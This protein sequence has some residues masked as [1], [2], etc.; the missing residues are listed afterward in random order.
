MNMSMCRLGCIGLLAVAFAATPML[1]SCDS[2]TK[3][4]DMAKSVGLDPAQLA[5]K[6]GS[7]SGDVGGL[8][9]SMNEL[10][11]KAGTDPKGAIDK[12]SA[13]AKSF[14]A[15]NSAVSGALNKLGANPDVLKSWLGGAGSKASPEQLKALT[16]SMSKFGADSSKFQGVLNDVTGKLMKNPTADGINGLKGAFSELSTSGKS[17]GGSADS[18]AKQ[19]KGLMG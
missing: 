11:A 17:L 3:V 9:G 16:D 5:S 1:V 2:A 12:F 14:T 10:L 15:D 6:L 4:A 7:V 13:A 19:L 18:L 8:S